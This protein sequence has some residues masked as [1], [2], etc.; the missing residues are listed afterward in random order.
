MIEGS[1]V[2]PIEL[3]SKQT[4]DFLNNFHWLNWKKISPKTKNYIWG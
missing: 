3:F 4:L 2:L 1:T